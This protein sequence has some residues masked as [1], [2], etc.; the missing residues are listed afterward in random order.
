[1]SEPDPTSRWASLSAA[2]FR[3]DEH[4]RP[5][6]REVRA[7]LAHVLEVFD[8]SLDPV[9]DFEGAAVRRLA[10]SLHRALGGVA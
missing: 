3:L 10:L 7:A 8:A 4:P 1:M 5:G 2:A 6:L 9:D